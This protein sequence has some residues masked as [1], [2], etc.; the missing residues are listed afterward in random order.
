MRRIWPIVILFDENVIEAE[1]NTRKNK[2]LFRSEPEICSEDSL[3]YPTKERNNSLFL[4]R[5]D[6]KP[7]I[8]ANE[9][10]P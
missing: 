2:K 4:E 5:N 7:S 9:S 10:P 6:R 8:L 1:K 3:F